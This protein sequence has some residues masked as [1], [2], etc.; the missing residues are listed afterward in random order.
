[1]SDAIHKTPK[2]DTAAPHT[3]QSATHT[4]KAPISRSMED[5]KDEA[6]HTATHVNKDEITET[7]NVHSDA[8]KTPSDTPAAKLKE[9]MH[10]AADAAKGLDTAGETGVIKN[11]SESKHTTAAHHNINATATAHSQQTH[12]HQATHSQTQSLAQAAHAEG[13]SV[14]EKLA[15]TAHGI[16]ETA[17][18]M[19]SAAG[20]ALSQAAE[21]IST[22]AS[23]A[24]SAIAHS[25]PVESIKDAIN[26]A[27]SQNTNEEEST[28]TTTHQ[29]HSKEGEHAGDEKILH[30]SGGNKSSGNKS[31]GG[32]TATQHKRGAAEMSNDSAE[33]EAP[34]VCANADGGNTKS[35]SKKACTNTTNTNKSSGSKKECTGDATAGEHCNEGDAREGEGIATNRARRSSAQGKQ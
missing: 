27:L 22:A 26:S 8:I 23:N 24:A 16:A 4:A 14:S 21:S 9:A 35:G 29:Q 18:N 3:A 30:G 19:A 31:S 6:H 10:D 25:A 1:M 7:V 13:E 12:G 33:N 34:A 2:T 5:A 28:A 32:K 15:E 11:P 17:S 20:A